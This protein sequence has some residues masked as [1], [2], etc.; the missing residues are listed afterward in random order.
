MPSYP[1]VYKTLRG[2][3]LVYVYIADVWLDV[4]MLG[5]L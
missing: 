4:L 3:G 5:G 1:C 2:G